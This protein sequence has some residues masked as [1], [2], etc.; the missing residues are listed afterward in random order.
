[1]SDSRAT[2]RGWAEYRRST[3][4]LPWQSIMIHF[5]NWV[6]VLSGMAFLIWWDQ[7]N[8]WSQWKF[9]GVMLLVGLPYVFL[10]SSLNRRVKLNQMRDARRL[11]K[12]KHLR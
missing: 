12:T 10:W 11:A 7:R 1:M 8:H 9:V 2:L 6:V 3:G 5:L 4:R